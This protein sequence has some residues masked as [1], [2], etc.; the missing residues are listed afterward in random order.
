MMNDG[1][2][3]WIVFLPQ[4][5]PDKYPAGIARIGQQ[6]CADKIELTQNGDL[7]F[8]D[9]ND[10]FIFGF[11]KGSWGRFESTKIMPNDPPYHGYGGER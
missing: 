11:A 2:N 9:K 4:L 1:G 3:T 10:N 7:I 5:D 6:V 8:C